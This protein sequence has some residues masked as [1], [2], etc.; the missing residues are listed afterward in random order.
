MEEKKKED[1]EKVATA[2]LSITA[3]QK[4][5][6]HKKESEV[7]KMEVD[8]EKEEKEKKPEPAAEEAP[9]PTTETLSNPARVLKQ[10]LRVIQFEEEKYRPI[11]DISIGGIIMMQN[12][13]GEPCEVVKPVEI[14]KIVSGDID[15]DEPEPPEPFEYIE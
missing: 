13:T 9:E 4:K 11:K 6:E 3:K 5:K 7:E 8:K 15:E 1:R 10:Q 14:K 2:V 12:K